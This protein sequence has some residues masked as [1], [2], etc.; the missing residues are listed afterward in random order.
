MQLTKKKLKQ[1]IKEEMNELL[2]MAGGKPGME[3]QAMID[4]IMKM[5]APL[6]QHRVA[7]IHGNVE[8]MLS[9]PM[10]RENMQDANYTNSSNDEVFMAATKGNDPNAWQEMVH[11]VAMVKMEDPWQQTDEEGYPMDPH[12]PAWGGTASE[13][14]Q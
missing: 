14:R 13:Y 10:V 4:D 6:D 11:R 8:Q 2:G 3:K 7:I 9:K 1:I 12:N 5:L